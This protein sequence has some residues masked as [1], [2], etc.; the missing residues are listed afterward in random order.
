MEQIRATQ[1][2]SHDDELGRAW[3][4]LPGHS[5]SALPATGPLPGYSSPRVSDLIALLGSV[6]LAGSSGELIDQ[7]RGLEELKSAI[8]GLQARAAVAFDHAQRA[9]QAAAGVPASEQGQGVGAQ[10]AL[11]R[12]ESPNKGPRLLGLARALVTEMPRTLAALESG[13]LNEWRAMLLVKET[14]CLSAEDRCAV[15]EELAPDWGTFE[16]KGDRAIIAAVKAAAYRRDPRSVA[17]RASHAATERTVSLRPAPDTMTYLTALLP[18]AQGVAAYAALTREADTARAGGDSRSRGQVMADTLVERVTG[19]PGGVAGI[20]LDLVMT[21]RTLFQADS[22]PARL[23]GYGIVPAQWA[24]KLLREPQGS[25]RQLGEH[26]VG[27]RKEGEASGLA[28]SQEGEASGLATSQEGEASGLA[29]GRAGSPVPD[30]DFTVWLRRLYTAPGTGELLSMDSTARLFPPR[31]R[32]FIEARDDTCRTPYCDAP[33]RHI[34]HVLPWRSGGTTTPNNGAGLCEACNHT[35]E[36]PG[37][38]SKS[39]TGD[40]QGGHTL[41]ISTPTGH[42]YVSKAATTAGA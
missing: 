40:K 23:K 16:G 34:D 32:R 2:P 8:T 26:Q 35:K 20:N 22:E 1:T 36:N 41:Q 3:E 37:W 9:E 10:L 24:R 25:K 38:N 12:R 31:L 29:T 11:A 5:H 19:T 28:T 21:D 15:D 7:L 4:A 18:V 14:A 6:P 27:E 33:I 13:Q 39:V 42:A 30:R 17:Q